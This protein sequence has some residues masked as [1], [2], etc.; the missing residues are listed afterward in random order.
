MNRFMS[1]VVVTRPIRMVVNV[2]LYDC[3]HPVHLACKE[4]QCGICNARDI[5]DEEFKA[6]V[7][8]TVSDLV[9][10]GKRKRIQRV[11]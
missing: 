7:A 5:P 6:L 9:I 3:G 1:V 8:P 11:L 4:D 2:V 10:Q